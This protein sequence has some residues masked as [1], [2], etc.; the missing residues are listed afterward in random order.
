MGKGKGTGRAELS[1]HCLMISVV[2]INVLCGILGALLFS[3]AI[4]LRVETEVRDWVRELG[5]YQYWNGL[6]ILMAAGAIIVI[7]SFFGCCGAFISNPCL[8]GTSAILVLL[9]LILELA[10]GIYILVNGTETSQ[11]QPWLLKTF[12][13]LILDSNYNDDS[14]RLL[15][16]VQEKV[17]CCGALN[18]QDYDRHR[19]PISD[20]CRDK[21]SGNVYSDGCVKRFS[22]FIEKRAG[23]IAGIAI[24]IGTL[25]LILVAFTFCH[26][27]NIRE[28][29]EEDARRR[30]YDSVPTTA[31]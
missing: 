8:L 11:L 15:Q 22:L 2:I 29:P 4:W 31:Y 1:E 14:Y 12:N 5:M 18:Y 23:W 25:Q 27:R 26:C 24:F 20:Y 17:G 10:G 3:L 6:Y 16:K 21:I 19:L 30:K 7:I 13:K 9:A 28:E